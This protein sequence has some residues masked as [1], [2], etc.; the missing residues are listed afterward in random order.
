MKGLSC[1]SN[2]L[3]NTTSSILVSLPLSIHCQ[4]CGKM[5][6]ACGIYHFHPFTHFITPHLLTHLVNPHPPHTPLPTHPPL[7]PPLTPYNH[8]PTHSPHTPLPTRP[9]HTTPPTHPPHTPPLPLQ[10]PWQL[11]GQ[12]KRR[13]GMGARQ[14]ERPATLEYHCKRLSRFSISKTSMT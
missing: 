5:C 6:L 13:G 14:H 1:R 10:R 8:P 12:Q 4:T 9:P 11:G 2:F 7:K 3:I